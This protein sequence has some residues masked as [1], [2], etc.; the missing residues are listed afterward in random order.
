MIIAMAFGTGFNSTISQKVFSFWGHLRLQHYEAYNGS[1]SEE[2]PI[3]ANDTVVQL[4]RKNPAVKTVQQFATKWTALKTNNSMEGVLLK[5]VGRDFDQAYF[6]PFIIEGSFI[7]FKDSGFSEQVIIS[8]YLSDLLKIKVGDKI[9]SYFVQD[10]EIPKARPL[11]VCGIYKTGIEDYDK[12]FAIADISFIRK[13]N[14]WEQDEI[15]GYEVFLYNYQRMNSVNEQLLEH[16][17]IEWYSRTIKE[18]YPNIFDWLGLQQKNN[19]ILICVMS[20]VAIIN[21]ITCL[22]ILVLE[23]TRM[24][25]ILKAIGS[26]DWTIQKIFLLHAGYIA[27]TGIVMGTLIGLSLAWLQMKTGFI[28]L[29]EE[30]YYISK[31]PVD[32]RFLHVLL[33]DGIT[34]GLCLLVLIIPTFIIKKVQPVKAIQ[35]R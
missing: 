15:G 19:I 17:P 27:M 25:G 32:I 24:I 3:R 7:S 30:A 4:L 26:N 12:N 5:G 11:Y 20:I 31:A 8:K 13:C 33:I 18:I 2:S 6:K 1:L 16:L 9:I 29:D 14:N 35:F 34:L 22:I 23:R 10:N 21:M 28:H